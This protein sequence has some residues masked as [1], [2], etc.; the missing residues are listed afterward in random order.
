MQQCL[1]C[2]ENYDEEFDMCPYCG[3]EEDTPA[4]EPYFLLPGM[5]LEDRYIIGKAL[6]FGGFGITYKAWDKN[7]SIVVAVKEYYYTGCAVRV[8]GTQEVQI[9]AK[10]RRTEYQH[11]LM[12][13]LDEARY[14]AKFSSNNNIVNVYE[15][16]EANN[17]AYM[18]MEY[19]EGVPLIDPLKSGALSTDECIEVMQGIC[20]ALKEV[21]E[22]G[23]LHRDISPDNIMLCSNGTVKLF[24]FGA[25]RFSKHESPEILKLTQVMKPGYSPPEQYQAVSKQGPWTDIYALGATLYYMITGV[26]P[27]ESTNRKTEDTLTPPIVINPDIPEYLNDTILRA[28]AVDMHIRFSSVSEFEKVLVGEKKVLGVAKEKKRRKKNRIL[29]VTAAIFILSIAFSVFYYYFDQR[30]QEITLPDSEIEFWIMLPED[31]GDADTKIRSIEVIINTFN[32]TYDNVIINLIGFKQ[33]E[34]IESIN[35]AL[36][37]GNLPNLF[38]SDSMSAEILEQTLNFEDALKQ[39]NASEVLFFNQFNVAFPDGKQFPLGFIMPI[40]FYN[41]APFDDDGEETDDRERF[42][43]GKSARFVGTIRDYYDVQNALAGKYYIEMPDEIVCTFAALISIGHN[44]NDEKRT[45]DRFLAYLLSGFAQDFLHIQFQSGYL[46]LNN[47][48]LRNVFVST[49]SEFTGFFDNIR[50]FTIQGP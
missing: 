28:M 27:E 33:E 34:Y 3:Y 47:T 50:S 29:G 10:N 49:Y 20:A 36:K 16:F 8:P 19:M 48:I 40:V 35:E 26:K 31:D 41:I 11:F 46:P 24:D 21:H 13:F 15:F 22:N 43:A 2:F 44:S 38:E 17:T 37:A 7:L 9:Y 12:R 1:F 39:V 45:T 32:E 6:G 42:L 30:L 5:E 18:V 14:T 25:A 4:D 23:I